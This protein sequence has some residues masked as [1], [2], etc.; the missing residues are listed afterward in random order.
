MDF[1]TT[2][3][4]RETAEE[5]LLKSLR[6]RRKELEALLAE[7][8]DHWNYEDGIYRFYHHS[9]KVYYLQS[10]T[11]RIVD[12]L[13]TLVPKG[14]E[15]NQM[16]LDILAEGTGKK[17]TYDHNSDWMRHTRPIVEAFFHAKFFLETAVKYAEVMKDVEKPPS[18][19]PSGWAAFLYLYN[20][21]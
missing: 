16:F 11:E 12:T 20:L 3:K 2:K 14:I 9:F 21:R 17:F 6:N 15:L 5:F 8:N 13:R 7:T 1:E 19:L 4:R 18:L 10:S